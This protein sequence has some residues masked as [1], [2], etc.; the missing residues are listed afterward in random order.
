MVVGYLPMSLSVGLARVDGA[1][2]PAAESCVLFDDDENGG[3]YWF[4]HPLFERLAQS[5]GQ[6]IDLYGSAEFRGD[7]LAALNGTLFEARELVLA[8]PERWSVHVGTQTAP[9]RC[10]L[11]KDVER[12]KFLALIDGLVDLVKQARKTGRPIVCDGD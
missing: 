12:P 3:Y 11:F 2:W 6:Y 8:Q 4:L 10:E 5:T 1:R 7:D 9:V